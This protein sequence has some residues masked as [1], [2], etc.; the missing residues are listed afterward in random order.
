MSLFSGKKGKNSFAIG[1]TINLNCEIE[2][3]VVKNISVGLGIIFPVLT[4]WENDKKIFFKLGWAD[5][6]QKIA[7]NKFS[8]G[9][10]VFCNYNF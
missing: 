6:E 9:T 8:I 3:R 5:D 7:Y 2:K 10:S 1:R 4:K